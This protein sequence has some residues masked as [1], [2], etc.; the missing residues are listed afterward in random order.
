MDKRIKSH[1]RIVVDRALFS[2]LFVLL[3]GPTAVAQSL[4]TGKGKIAGKALI[5]SN[6]KPASVVRVRLMGETGSGQQDTMTDE[7][8]AFSFANLKPGTYQ[9]SLWSPGFVLDAGSELA[10]RITL[11]EGEER[12]GIVLRLIKGGVITGRLTD[13]DDEPVSAIRV[14]AI[15]VTSDEAKSKQ[16]NEPPPGIYTDDRGIYRI[17]GI[18]PG[19]YHIVANMSKSYYNRSTRSLIATYYPAT[20]FRSQATEIEVAAGQVIEG[21]DFKLLNRKGFTV[22]GRVVRKDRSTPLSD[23]TVTITEK[24]TR[25]QI[26]GGGTDGQGRYTFDALPSGEYEVY[27]EPR[28]EKDL[29][30]EFKTI[31][32]DA[33]DQLAVD[34]ELTTGATISGIIKMHDGKRPEKIQDSRIYV[35]HNETHY[36]GLWP[37]TL[38]P[39]KVNSDSSFIIGGIPGG[40]AQLVI[41][42]GNPDYYVVSISRKEE[43]IVKLNVPAGEQIDDITVTLSDG[44]ASLEGIVRDKDSNKAARGVGVSLLP[45]S[46]KK[47]ETALYNYSTQSDASGRYRITG[48]AP[49]KYMIIVGARGGA[50]DGDITTAIRPSVS[51]EIEQYL[52][53]HKEKAIR[54]E[55]KRGE[56]KIADLFSPSGQD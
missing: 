51:A 33:G 8:G 11:D 29:L 34:F 27:A 42:P 9:L 19:R 31:T 45:V 1:S 13:E 12:S 32:I 18:P 44:A 53:E 39:R 46:E 3:I 14:S 56:K 37:Y 17:I 49:G 15:P 23:T 43:R 25:L 22:A 10:A 21:L 48:I 38:W 5:A 41:E 6:S 7:S 20:A 54:V 47:R 40:E 16:A 55:F 30:S 52:A 28:R 36:R 24:G 26:R 4:S 35:I 2:F 50:P